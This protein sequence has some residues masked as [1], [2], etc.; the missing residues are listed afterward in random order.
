MELGND[1]PRLGT[2]RV[3]DR[4]QPDDRLPLTNGNPG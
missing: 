3:A 1:L 2:D 4:N